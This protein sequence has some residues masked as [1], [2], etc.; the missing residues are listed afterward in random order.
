M[1][2]NHDENLD[3]KLKSL[4]QY[5]TSPENTKDDPC[6]GEDFD[7]WRHRFKL[8]AVPLVLLDVLGITWRSLMEGVDGDSGF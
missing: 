3:K 5:K 4:T 1:A 8:K 7:G 6:V 2:R